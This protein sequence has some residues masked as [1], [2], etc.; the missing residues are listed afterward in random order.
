MYVCIYI[1]IYIHMSVYRASAP[2][3]AAADT[4]R[5]WIAGASPTPPAAEAAPSG[6]GAP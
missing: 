4:R 2:A 5:A 3:I 6:R 1:Y